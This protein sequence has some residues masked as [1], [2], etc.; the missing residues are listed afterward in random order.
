MKT[1]N[2][3]RHHF[4]L[5]VLIFCFLALTGLDA[6]TT[7]QTEPAKRPMTLR[8]MMEFKQIRDPQISDDGTWIAYNSQPDRGN[9]EVVVYHTT[10]LTKPFAQIPR[11][12]K[13]VISGD[14]KWVAALIAP[15]AL[16]LEKL[17]NNINPNHKNGIEKPKTGM[18]LLDTTSGEITSF[19][20]VKAF[21]FSENSQ[22]LIMTG[23]P[24][25]E[26]MEESE[27]ED[28]SETT[29]IN[30]DQ[31]D[32]WAQRAYSLVL[33]HLPT[34]RD[35]RIEK[36]IYY[37]LDP[38]NR[39]LAYSVY[40]TANGGNGIFVHNLG[41]ADAP[42]KKI[43]T[44][45][46]AMYTNLTWSKTK[47][48]LAFL[49]HR[50]KKKTVHTGFSSGLSV[51][52]GMRNKHFSAVSKE[53]IPTGWMI[54]AENK[55][56]WTEDGE[57]LFFGFKPYFEYIQ[58][59]TEEKEKDTQ[60]DTVDLFNIDH[61]LEKA[62][63]DVWHWNDPMINPHQKKHWEKFRKQI[64]LA[65]YHYHTNRF[66]PLADKLMPDLQVPQNPQV[67][68]GTSDQPYLKEITWDGNY[69][70]VFISYLNTGF[71]KKILTR[72]QFDVSLSPNGR[73]VV[74]YNDKNW[75]LYDVR[76]KYARR[77]TDTIKTPFYNED[78]DYPMDVPSY[79]IAGWTENDN[80]VIIYDKYDIWEFFTGSANNRFTCL[81]RGIGRQNKLTFNIIKTDP[82]A[83]FFS[84][85]E[86]CL[87]SAYSDTEKYT[88]FYSL[89]LGKN[90]GGPKKLLQEKKTFTFLKKAKHA[91]TYLFT[92][93]SFEEFPD[94][95]IS[96]PDFT[97]PRKVTDVNPRMK[98][99]LWG[100]SELVEWEALDGTPLQGVLI[101]PENYD[102]SKRYPVLVYFYRLFSQR[103]YEFN[104]VVINHRPCFPYYTG[105]GYVV[106]L[107]DIRFEV[108][109]PGKSTFQCIVPGVQKLIDMGIAD[110]K[111]IGIHGH[112]WS[113]YQTAFIVTQTNIF[114]AAVA[115]APV[116]NMT[117]AYSG[118]RWGSGVARQF[119]YEKSQSRI[120]KSL[121][122]SP[123][124]YIENS[125]VFFAN[126]IE[127]PLLIE[128]GDKDGAVPWYQGIELYLAM[129]RLQKNCIL[130]QYNEEPHHLKKYA[131]KVDYTIKMK[132]FL[133]HYLKGIPAPDWMTKGVPYKKK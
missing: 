41:K 51:W 127:T 16:E 53:Q 36:V 102:S 71:R 115:G 35:I 34:S 74:Y 21:F 132:Q 110:P 75:Y 92:R 24:A 44:E 101:K 109:H 64:Y 133:D 55:L 89:T 54:P 66:I 104:E 73:F 63:V 8:D 86:K 6:Q 94:I 114:A 70:D 107:P 2:P 124:L 81:T 32:R 33:R 62:G 1:M 57:R 123:E 131:N 31:E 25:K 20:K 27:E 91:D 97:A 3:K 48:R 126:R 118:I 106:F 85:N 119:Q 4:L 26:E 120:G 90:N 128:F 117:S 121:W 38:S 49:F 11:G 82:D 122:E 50:K 96:G 58:T 65:V 19:E 29:N 5:I 13:P 37:A 60:T 17:A 23:Y 78:H 52:D 45:A 105:H 113:G 87:L 30:K 39:F 80:S 116:A 9:G 22:W 12:K 88:A 7:A 61:I 83:K 129:R 93:Q 56:Q 67:A 103:L 84:K 69:R 43:H 77:L 47:S 76:L 125:P 112:S 18:A 15:D 10:D 72:H 42:L 46:E 95:W 111:A 130:L 98:D 99:F 59:L 28:D 100:T 79:G 40:D 68:M 14:G 108:G